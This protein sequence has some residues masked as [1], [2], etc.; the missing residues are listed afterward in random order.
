MQYFATDSKIE[1]LFEKHLKPESVNRSDLINSVY[2]QLN[3]SILLSHM[4][5]K[6]R[7]YYRLK[8]IFISTFSSVFYLLV[9]HKFVYIDVKLCHQIGVFTPEYLNANNKLHETFL[10]SHFTLI[11]ISKLQLIN[12]KSFYGFLIILSV[13]LTLNPGS[14]CKYQILKTTELDISETKSLHLMH[15]NINSL[16]TKIDELR[17]I[18][19][20]SNPAV[21]GILRQS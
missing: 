21:I 14:G 6:Q 4:F 10:S 20:P 3:F 12:N 5:L 7:R 15:S 13:D 8:C 2:L 17:Y 16:L 1:D 18:A 19:R 11:A 9:T